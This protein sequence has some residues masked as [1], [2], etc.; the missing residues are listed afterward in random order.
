M[1]LITRS[2]LL[3]L[4][5]TNT[6]HNGNRIYINVRVIFISDST[7]Y[8]IRKEGTTQRERFNDLNRKNRRRSERIQNKNKT[9]QTAH[10]MY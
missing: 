7:L 8:V 1:F 5:I 4:L 9:K 3:L 2:K 10:R 6:H